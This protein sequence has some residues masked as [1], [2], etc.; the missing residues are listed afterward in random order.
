MHQ[1][2]HILYNYIIQY[3]SNS[4]KH[5]NKR[6]SFHY[7]DKT[8]KLIFLQQDNFNKEIKRRGGAKRVEE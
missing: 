5:K 1:V 3:L 2:T 7:I 6:F 8:P 4:W